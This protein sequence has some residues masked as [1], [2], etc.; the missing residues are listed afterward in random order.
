MRKGE[1]EPGSCHKWSSRICS[2]HA[3]KV[4]VSSFFLLLNW[5]FLRAHVK[6]KDSAYLGGLSALAREAVTLLHTKNHETRV[7]LWKGMALRLLREM[8][9]VRRLDT[10]LLFPGKNP[11]SPV[12]F[13]K[14]RVKVF[15]AAQVKK[16]LFS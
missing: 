4:N 6:W 3:R 13:K 16:I 2:S 5:R 12:L 11:Q 9:R 15:S 1:G 8:N 7:V 14:H 10:D